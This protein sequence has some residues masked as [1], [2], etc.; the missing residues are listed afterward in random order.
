MDEKKKTPETENIGED[1]TAVPYPEKDS[2][3]EKGEKNIPRAQ[4]D[5]GV[6]PPTS[7]LPEEPPRYDLS[8]R[9]TREE[10]LSCLRRGLGRRAGKGRLTAQTVVLVLIA[11][12]CIVTYIASGLEST[13]SL[14][15]GIAALAVCVLML[16]VPEVAVRRMADKQT[17][18][19]KCLRLR[20][21][22]RGIGFGDDDE[23]R[24]FKYK[25]CQARAYEDMILFR[26]QDGLVAVPRRL[27]NGGAWE[28][29]REA[30]NLEVE[31]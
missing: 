16:V 21:Y 25:K 24:F 29:I 8:I 7:S 14:G 31:K 6:K 10:V 30:M 28:L 5:E 26:F 19:D 4:E 12:Y 18:M 17:A 1:T 11:A 27:E 20:V 23:F 15:I 13:A 22:D 2:D 9:L 3:G